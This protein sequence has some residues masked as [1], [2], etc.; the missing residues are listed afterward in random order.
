[1]ISGWLVGRKTGNS[2]GPAVG[3]AETPCS[4]AGEHPVAGDSL[5]DLQGFEHPQPAE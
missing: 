1:V 4:N 5:T 3:P 2:T